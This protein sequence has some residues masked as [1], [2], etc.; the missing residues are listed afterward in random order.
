MKFIMKYL[1]VLMLGL[2]LACEAASQMPALHAPLTGA[3]AASEAAQASPSRMQSHSLQPQ[4]ALQPPAAQ[5]QAQPGQASPDGRAG[6]EIEIGAAT[7]ALLGQQAEKRV[8][9]VERP[10]PG[11]AAQ[12]SWR[13]YLDSFKH[14]IPERT[15]N[16]IDSKVTK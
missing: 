4:S 16:H 10:L 6:N 2:G 14:P 1:P 12:L 13:R 3:L 7:R 5:Q 9:A 11:E 15:Q 8:P